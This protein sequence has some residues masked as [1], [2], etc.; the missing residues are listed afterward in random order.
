[1]SVPRDAALSRHV[2]NRRGATFQNLGDLS[3]RQYWVVLGHHG[4]IRGCHS[5]RKVCVHSCLF[6]DS[7][8]DMELEACCRCQS[9]GGCSCLGV[10]VELLDDDGV[11]V[12][13]LK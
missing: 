6:R 9:V 4:V 10:G 1:M 7:K 12:V 8:T 13:L 5:L 2:V 3:D 11:V